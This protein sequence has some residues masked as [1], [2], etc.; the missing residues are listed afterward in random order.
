ME[1]LI[2]FFE[3]AKDVFWVVDDQYRLVYGNKS[4]YAQVGKVYNIPPKKGDNILNIEAV[5]TAE[6][7]L[8]KNNYDKAFELE[9]YAAEYASK[10]LGKETAYQ[11]EFKLLKTFLTFVS[12]RATVL[13]VA[14][15]AG[16]QPETA[17]AATVSNFKNALVITDKGIITEVAEKLNN[18][19]GNPFKADGTQNFY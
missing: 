3:D 2:S 10:L 18:L 12:V 19:L 11:F 9:R 1:N 4:F 17:N 7:E 14:E 5:G 6:Y 13:P 16:S 15:I 8:W